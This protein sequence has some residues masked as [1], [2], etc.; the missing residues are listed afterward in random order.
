MPLGLKSWTSL[1]RRT[2]H[3]RK[4]FTQADPPATL[5]FHAPLPLRQIIIRRGQT[6]RLGG[7]IDEVG[8]TWVQFHLDLIEVIPGF[9]L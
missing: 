8:E 7:A 2:P 4:G 9:H 6:L 3:A 1:I 5:L